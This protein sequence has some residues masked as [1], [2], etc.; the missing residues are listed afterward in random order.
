MEEPPLREEDVQLSDDE[1]VVAPACTPISSCSRITPASQPASQPASEPAPQPDSEPSAPTETFLCMSDVRRSVHFAPQYYMVTETKV[2][3]HIGGS[4]AVNPC[5]RWDMRMWEESVRRCRMRV[6]DQPSRAEKEYAIAHLLTPPLT[7]SSAWTVRVTN[8]MNVYKALRECTQ[9]L[10]TVA[11]LFV[12]SKRSLLQVGRVVVKRPSDGRQGSYAR[13]IV[14]T[15]LGRE[16]THRVAMRIFDNDGF[17]I[18]PY[19]SS[20]LQVAYHTHVLVDAWLKYCG[21]FDPVYAFNLTPSPTLEWLPFSTRYAFQIVEYHFVRL[22]SG[23][24][25]NDVLDLLRYLCNADMEERERERI[26]ILI[27]RAQV[28]TL[29][30]FHAQTYFCHNDPAARNF[31]LAY[32]ERDTETSPARLIHMEGHDQPYIVRIIDFDIARHHSRHPVSK[33]TADYDHPVSG[34]GFRY[35][36]LDYITLLWCA[37]EEYVFLEGLLGITRRILDAMR[38]AAGKW[39]QAGSRTECVLNNLLCEAPKTRFGDRDNN[40]FGP[41]ILLLKEDVRNLDMRQAL[42][43]FL[44][45]LDEFQL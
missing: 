12:S 24:T 30:S 26:A 37:Y 4:N 31:V 16:E 1:G 22:P 28:F 39:L 34:E 8:A 14:V 18:A 45:H 20:V 44:D 21:P 36:L 19:L 38:R 5:Q 10:I 41:R 35:F 29:A 25:A 23:E 43:L 3:V 9:D 2:E 6:G 27:L 13:V 32:P 15:I 33:G 40:K 7:I 42:V 11:R 17:A